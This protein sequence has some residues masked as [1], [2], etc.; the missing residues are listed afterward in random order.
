MMVLQKT[1][2]ESLEHLIFIFRVET[3]RDLCGF[4]R[5]ELGFK[6]RNEARM[7]QVRC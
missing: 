3:E 5:Y 4:S 1:H 7:D 6:C 2:K